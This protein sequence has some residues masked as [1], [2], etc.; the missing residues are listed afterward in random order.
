MNSF[1]PK[2]IYLHRI[3]LV[4]LVFNKFNVSIKPLVQN[5]DNKNQNENLKEYSLINFI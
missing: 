1:E 4:S 3:N 2:V 5:K